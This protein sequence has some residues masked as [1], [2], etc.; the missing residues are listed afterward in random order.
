M[1]KV[2]PALIETGHYEHPWLGVSGL[3]LNP[4]IA[5][6]MDLNPEQ[7]GALIVDVIPGSPADKVGLQGSDRQVTIDGDQIRVGGDVIT[8]IDGQVVRTFDDLVTYLARST[9]IGQTVTTDVLSK[10]KEEQVEVTLV[11]RPE[12]Q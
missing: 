4:D 5:K 9:E 1:Q 11:A 12:S 3:S 6:A 7:R 2:V 10:G 8:A